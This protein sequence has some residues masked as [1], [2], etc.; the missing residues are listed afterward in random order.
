MG[1]HEIERHLDRVEFESVRIGDLQ[2]VLVHTG[3]FMAREPDVANLA[4]IA[5]F[6]EGGMCSFVSKDPMRIFV[7]KYLTN[8]FSR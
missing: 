3:I 5:R 6:D 8:A 1:V 7:P 2:H 4:G